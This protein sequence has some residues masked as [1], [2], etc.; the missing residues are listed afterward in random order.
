MMN[1]P[2][3][4]K[5]R[6]YYQAYYNDNFL[7]NF[8]FIFD[9]ERTFVKDGNIITYKAH[10]QNVYKYTSDNKVMNFL[11]SHSHAIGGLLGGEITY[12][13]DIQDFKKASIEKR[14]CDRLFFDL[15]LEGNKEVDMLKDKFKQANTTL[16]GKEYRKTIKDLQKQFQHLIFDENIL[17]DVYEDAQKL[18]DYLSKTSLKPYLVFS[19]SK[20]Y[21]INVFFDE[22][23]L[24]NL[25][26]ICETLTM[27]FKNE[28]NIKY[29]DFNVFDR[30]KAH[31]RLQRVQY[32]IHSKTNLKTTPL[33]L[34]CQYDEML[35]IIKKN[36]S[37][38]IDFDFESMQ[39]PDGFTNMLKKLDKE[40]LFK[41][42][43]RR[44]ELESINKA[45]KLQMQKRYGKN[46]KSFNDI[47][48]RDIA[49][50]YG[51]DGQHQGDKIIASCPFH[52][53]VHPS[54]VIFEKRFY[55]STCNMTLNYYDFISKLEG[56]NDK[57]KIIEIASKFLR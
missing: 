9:K 28:L 2:H 18:C 20:G 56:T 13:K 48:L 54:S 44:Q 53:D 14:F 34:E 29:F 57:E 16:E 45:K 4:N 25:S 41:N 21:H 36:K 17:L 43:Q 26:Q 12:Y 6:K 47:D 31:K 23:Q 35:S 46:Y 30:N 42:N 51:I 5:L 3:K 40:I 49:R 24:T 32:G 11:T 19:G 33:P 52:H 27:S 55:C 37:N 7:R 10:N 1:S 15:D 50:A 22:L 39:A 8:R 38:P